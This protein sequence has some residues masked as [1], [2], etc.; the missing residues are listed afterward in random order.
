M[1]RRKELY[2]LFLRPGKKK[3]I[4]KPMNSSGLDS[5]MESMGGTDQLTYTIVHV[6]EYFNCHF[7]SSENNDILPIIFVRCLW[8]ESEILHS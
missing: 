5:W 3:K 4:E 7:F 2:P 1:I 6:S 8:Q